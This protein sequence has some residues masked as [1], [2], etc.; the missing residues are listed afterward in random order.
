MWWRGTRF[1]F[2]F[3]LTML[4]EGQARKPVESVRFA[5]S[6]IVPTSACRGYAVAGQKAGAGDRANA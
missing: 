2:H 6:H 1:S 3:I 5:L 4:T